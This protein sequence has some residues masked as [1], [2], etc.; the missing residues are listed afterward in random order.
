MVNKRQDAWTTFDDQ[1]LAET[2]LRYIKEGGTQIMAFE[3][4]GLELNRTPAACGFRW[5]SHV[6]KKYTDEIKQA[7]VERN[8]RFFERRLQKASIS[9]ADI[10]KDEYAKTNDYLK[11]L[12]NMI[13]ILREYRHELLDLKQHRQLKQE[14]EESKRVAAL[15]EAEEEIKLELVSDEDNYQKLIDTKDNLLDLMNKIKKKAQ[16]EERLKS[17]R[18]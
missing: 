15:K 4:V 13:R 18:V 3:E 16:R 12:D 2:T 11:A 8:R 14:L 17:D 10:Y 7:K 5:N 1:L 9:P 6:R